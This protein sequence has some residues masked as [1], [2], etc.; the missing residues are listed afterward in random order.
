MRYVD[1]VKIFGLCYQMEL[2]F[3]VFGYYKYIFIYISDDVYKGVKFLGLEF[4]LEQDVKL[5][6]SVIFQQII[7]KKVC[8]GDYVMVDVMFLGDVF[9]ILEWEI[10]YDGKRKVYKVINI[11]G[12]EY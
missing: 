9:F 1:L 8:L 5:Q 3:S 11:E 4:I 7:G 12:N 10:I 6:V 2:I